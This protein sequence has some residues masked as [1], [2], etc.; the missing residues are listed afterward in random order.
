[1]GAIRNFVAGKWGPFILFAPVGLS[2]WAD[3]AKVDL[4]N[5]T[6]GFMV[7]WFVV[8]SGVNLGRYARDIFKL[9]AAVHKVQ[10]T[11]TTASA[12]EKE[13]SDADSPS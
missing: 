9:A 12:T 10:Q 2:A 11:L 6:L 5:W 13:K 1:M 7:A 4:S 8:V 3:Y